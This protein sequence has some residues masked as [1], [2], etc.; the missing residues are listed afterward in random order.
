MKSVPESNA[1]TGTAAIFDVDGGGWKNVPRV[2]DSGSPSKNK[3][4][5][6]SAEFTFIL[7]RAQLT[8]DQIVHLSNSSTECKMN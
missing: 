7:Q 4:V 2:A 3:A 6:Y 1:L 5:D 8:H